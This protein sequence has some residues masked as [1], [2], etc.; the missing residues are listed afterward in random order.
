[1]IFHIEVRFMVSLSILLRITELFN[2][3]NGVKIKVGRSQAS[4]KFNM[5][6]RR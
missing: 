5:H 2:Y 3:E 6:A 4:T 1:M